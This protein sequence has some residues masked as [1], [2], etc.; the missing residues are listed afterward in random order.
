MFALDCTEHTVACISQ[1]GYN[2]SV[3]IETL[4]EGSG[5]DLHI[6][7]SLLHAATPSGAANKQSKRISLAQASFSR[8]MAAT[9]EL[10]V[11]SMGST[12]ITSRSS[13]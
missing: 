7:M 6:R 5:E 4:V 8:V 11:A 12:A 13:N 2:V 3:F 10:P 9:E 1:A